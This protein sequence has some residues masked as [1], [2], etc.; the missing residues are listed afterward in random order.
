MGPSWKAKCNRFVTCVLPIECIKQWLAKL[1]IVFGCVFIVFEFEFVDFWAFLL[2]GV[3]LFWG[4]VAEV[5]LSASSFLEVSCDLWKAWKCI[6]LLPVYDVKM[7]YFVLSVASSKVCVRFHL[8]VSVLN[9]SLHFQ[10]AITVLSF[11]CLTCVQSVFL[12]PQYLTSP[13]FF[14]SFVNLF[15][16]VL[17]SNFHV[18][19]LK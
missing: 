11:L 13:C 6:F 10:M 16:R 18:W 12:I 1:F 19:V 9:V 17:N 15:I 3:L 7:V 8:V 4:S 2:L 5:L 14:F